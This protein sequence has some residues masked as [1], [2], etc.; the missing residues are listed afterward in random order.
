MHLRP[1]SFPQVGLL[2]TV[3]QVGLE[4]S[5]GTV[6]NNGI[7]VFVGNPFENSWKLEK[8]CDKSE[9]TVLDSE[10]SCLQAAFEWL[11]HSGLSFP[12]ALAGKLKPTPYC[13]RTFCFHYG[14]SQGDLQAVWE[15]FW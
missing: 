8:G 3:F 10:R 11:E 14:Q 7:E 4:K 15:S 6:G 13:V 1:L 2:S 12:L 5:D 9:H